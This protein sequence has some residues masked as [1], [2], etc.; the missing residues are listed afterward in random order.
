MKPEFLETA[1]L[2]IMWATSHRSVE[3]EPIQ[4]HAIPETR[5]SRAGPTARHSLPL[6]EPVR[7]HA[8]QKCRPR[9]FGRMPRSPGDSDP[10]RADAFDGVVMK[11][12][13]RRHD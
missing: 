13:S 9:G 1:V 5:L 11:A 7:S 6:G 10:K 8:F 3:T 4:V 12:D 2:S